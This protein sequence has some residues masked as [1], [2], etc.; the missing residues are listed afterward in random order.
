MS[1]TVNYMS[2]NGFLAAWQLM[3]D[4]LFHSPHKLLPQNW[5]S[6]WLGS[7]LKKLGN[8]G[9]EPVVTLEIVQSCLETYWAQ[10]LHNPTNQP[11]WRKLCNITQ[12]DC[13]AHK[14]CNFGQQ[15]TTQ[16]RNCIIPLGIQPNSLQEMHKF[17]PQASRLFNV[18]S[19]WRVPLS[20][21]ET[22]L[23]CMGYFFLK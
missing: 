9:G 22:W 1:C 3:H 10:K 16:P 20:I 8:S 14:L 4:G 12:Q 2:F 19:G 11:S 23:A 5:S 21:E 15:S 18:P 13:S 7:S 17:L 6:C